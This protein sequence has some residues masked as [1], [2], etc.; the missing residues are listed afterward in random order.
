MAALEELF[1]A[2]AGLAPAQGAASPLAGLL[3]R[4]AAAAQRPEVLVVLAG[5]T[6]AHT[7]SAAVQ[8]KLAALAAAAPASLRLPNAVHSV[9]RRG[10]GPRCCSPHCNTAP[11]A[12]RLCRPVAA[13][14]AAIPPA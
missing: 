4:G 8:E 1:E 10:A 6:A 12:A 13:S 5:A 11:A 2:A 7:T 3:D 14:A 9:R